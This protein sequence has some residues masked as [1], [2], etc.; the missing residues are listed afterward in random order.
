MANYTQI[1]RGR[2]NLRKK[3]S[4]RLTAALLN[5]GTG[6]W[7][8]SRC[9][10]P[11]RGRGTGHSRRPCSRQE[12][13]SRCTRRCTAP[14]SAGTPP[15]P[16]PPTRSCSRRPRRAAARAGTASPPQG[17]PR[18]LRPLQRCRWRAATR[19]RRRDRAALEFAAAFFFCCCYKCLYCSAVLAA[20][21]V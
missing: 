18:V 6:I 14:S 20:G 8:V 1:K 2:L 16:R 3:R 4:D 17:Q 19:Q 11:A 5:R 10:R 9:C 15:P 7:P 13:R 12:R 21:T